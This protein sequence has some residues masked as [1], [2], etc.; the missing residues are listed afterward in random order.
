MTTFSKRHPLLEIGSLESFCLS[1]ENGLACRRGVVDNP[2]K[3][4]DFYFEPERS[5]VRLLSNTVEEGPDPVQ[6]GLN[7][8]K[9]ISSEK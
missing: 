2:A 5:L 1:D 6:V 4:P 8:M 3:P 7:N 9:K